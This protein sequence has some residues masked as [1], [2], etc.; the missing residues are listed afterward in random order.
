MSSGYDSKGAA[1]LLF[2]LS[3]L[4]HRLDDV[5]A[6]SSSNLAALESGCNVLR[7]LCT[8]FIFSFVYCIVLFVF[9]GF[10]VGFF[11]QIHSSFFACIEPLSSQWLLQ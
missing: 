9:F 5:K 3:Q 2:C 7:C 6:F 1:G 4:Q 8:C 10:F 11:F